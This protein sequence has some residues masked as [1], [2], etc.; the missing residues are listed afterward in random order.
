MIGFFFGEFFMMN[1]LRRLALLAVAVAV[2]VAAN[3]GRT[4]FLTWQMAAGGVSAETGWHD[5]AGAIELFA[6]LASVAAIAV[7][8]AG[9]NRNRM[10]PPPVEPPG[11]PV[12]RT[13]PWPWVVIAGAAAAVAGTQAWY[14]AHEWRAPPGTTW[15]LA[16][17]DGSWQPSPVPREAQA[18]LGNTSAD[19][20]AWRDPILGT[21]AWAYVIGWQ[22]DAAHGE[23]PEWHDPSVCLP[24]AGGTLVRDLGKVSLSIE[25]VPLTFSAF[26]FVIAGRTIET[27]FCHWDAELDQSR[28]EFPE[29]RGIRWRRLDRVF[30][31]RR[32]GAV[33]H[34]TLEIETRDDPEAVAWCRTWAPRLLHPVPL[35]RG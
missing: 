20:L 2:A 15:I 18:I 24:A 34:L 26:R 8:M 27:F 30:D 17:P 19:G 7:A 22:G 13:G 23:N 25:G 32:R 3:L 10:N 29:G 12:A 28:A 33:A 1:R 4:T 31:G 9:R 21:R 16:A 35:R 6:T 5:R 11:R 14:V